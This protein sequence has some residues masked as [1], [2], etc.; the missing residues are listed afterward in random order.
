M[1]WLLTERGEPLLNIN[2]EACSRSKDVIPGDL[3]LLINTKASEHYSALDFLVI[4]RDD[5]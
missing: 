3:Y 4:A 5:W 1:S 2:M